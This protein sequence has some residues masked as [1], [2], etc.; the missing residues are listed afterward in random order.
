MLD[1]VFNMLSREMITCLIG[2]YSAYKIYLFLYPQ[3]M[4]FGI[5]SEETKIQKLAEELAKWKKI[6]FEMSQTLERTTRF[7]MKILSSLPFGVMVLDKFGTVCFVNAHIED[8]LAKKSNDLLGLHYS[9]IKTFEKRY[10]KQP[11][12]FGFLT[13][14]FQENDVAYRQIYLEDEINRAGKMFSFA[15]YKFWDEAEF[16][17]GGAFVFLLEKENA[18]ELEELKAKNAYLEEL[19]ALAASVTHEI[20][21]PL[22]NL[23]SVIQMMNDKY[24]N[25][26]AIDV[27]GNIIY[28]EVQRANSLL[29][30]YLSVVRTNKTE[31]ELCNL[32]E[33]CKDVVTLMRCKAAMCDISVKEIYDKRNLP[34]YVNLAGFKQV[35]VNLLS[36]AIAACKPGGSVKVQ[37]KYNFSCQAAILT[38]VD[39]GVGMNKEALSNLG[40]PFFTSK[41]DGNGLGLFVC[42]QIISNC[43]GDVQVKSRPGKGT[44]FVITFPSGLVGG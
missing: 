22:Q 23:L 37:I 7:Y 44:T 28:K 27:Y 18:K 38:V 30:G 39:D 20:R 17:Y 6:A 40:R 16:D 43:G 19:K 14:M 5:V 24:K 15:L 10:L 36:N 32:T 26:Q 25:S 11:F 41:K 21:N 4:H 12:D 13:E 3:G 9:E 1:I 42:Y 31:W 35:L 33:V 29:S 8:F 2:F 34:S